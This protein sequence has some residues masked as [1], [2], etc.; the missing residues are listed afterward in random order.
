MEKITS[1]TALQD[2]YVGGATLHKAM[3]DAGISWGYLNDS[4]FWQVRE[5]CRINDGTYTPIH[6]DGDDSMRFLHISTD[7]PAKVSYTKDAEK[8]KQ[9]IQTRTTLAAYCEK[10]GLEVPPAVPVRDDLARETDAAA[11]AGRL[12]YD[13]T[14]AAPG[15]GSIRIKL[16]LIQHLIADVIADIG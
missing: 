13:Q 3:H 8:G 12:A 10:F 15:A 2:H 7:D 4:N 11:A 14:Q 9:D 16:N 6:I 5:Q 1:A